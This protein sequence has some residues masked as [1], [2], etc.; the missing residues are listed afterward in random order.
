[1]TQKNQKYKYQGVAIL[2]K[3]V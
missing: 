3:T 1:M 2:C